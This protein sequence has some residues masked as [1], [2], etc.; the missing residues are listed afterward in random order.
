MTYSWGRR[1]IASFLSAFL[2]AL[3]VHVVTIMLLSVGYLSSTQLQPGVNLFWLLS[4]QLE[5]VT[6]IAF[7][8]LIIG[9]YFHMYD[10]WWTALIG[11][12]L[13]VLIASVLGAIFIIGQEGVTGNY[14]LGLINFIFVFN[15]IYIAAMTALAATAGR[16]WYHAFARFTGS[17]SQN[18][19]IAFVRIPSSNLAE[20]VVTHIDRSEV[21][22]DIADHQWDDYVAALVRSGW[23]TVEVAAADAMADAVF[24]EDTAVVLGG[25][26]VIGRS[27]VESR[28]GE[29]ESVEKSLVEQG[30]EIEAIEEPGTLE[31][32]DVLVVGTTVYVGRSGRT[33]ADGVRQLRAIAGPLGY[34]VI[35]VPVSAT[36]HLKSAVTA[37]PDGTVVGA[38]DVVPDTS[39]FDRFLAVPEPS[40]G[41]VVVL[42]H[43]SVLIAASAPKSAELIEDLGYRVVQVDIGEFEKLE[44]SVTC[45]SLRAG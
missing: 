43:D 44:G 41:S 25:V 38:A 1:L 26:A 37:L 29:A 7:G 13:S 39:V 2:V 36:L 19:R 5:P 45:L 32:G 9:G 15:L 28:A 22:R 35:A 17:S 16:V 12:F 42:G 30:F 18:A 31:G 23:R 8:L 40:G 33:N 20:G 3:I 21:D 27:G 24:V 10:R 14:V 4:Q 6:L 34:T 11:S